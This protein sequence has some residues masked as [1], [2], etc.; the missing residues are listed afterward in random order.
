MSRADTLA[1]IDDLFES[2]CNLCKHRNDNNNKACMPCSIG[3]EIRSLGDQLNVGERDYQRV[4]D[5]GPDL[6]WSDIDFLKEREVPWTEIYKATGIHKQS[7]LELNKV[8]KGEAVL[9]TK[10]PNEEAI[11]LLKETDM[12]P[13]E[14]AA[15]TGANIKTVYTYSS[16]YR[17]KESRDQ[18]VKKTVTPVQ[19]KVEQENPQA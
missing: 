12:T 14:I 3:K 18:R 16:K 6:T 5:K 7:F 13:K 8:R 2:H 15:E 17:K 9:K 11:K 4:L 1:K 10:K 19:E